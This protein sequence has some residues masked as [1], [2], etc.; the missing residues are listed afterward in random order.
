MKITAL[1]FILNAFIPWTKTIAQ[2]APLGL[3][4]SSSVQALCYDSVSDILYAGGAFQFL[5]APADSSYPMNRIARWDGV[6]WDSLGSGVTEFRNVFALTMYNGNLIAGGTFDTIGGISSKGIAMWDGTDWNFLA[7]ITST[8]NAGAVGE[9]YTH[10]TDL[11]VGGTFDTINGVPASG[12]ARFD[13]ANWYLYPVISNNYGI[14]AIIIFN[15]ELYIGG[16]FSDGVGKSDILKF[17]G[18]DWVSVGGGFSGGF[19]WVN[20]FEIYQNQLYVAGYFQQSS[21]DPGNNI[22]IWDGS[23]WSQAGSGTMPSNKYEGYAGV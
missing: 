22:A 14:A 16:N 2:F 10:G 5:D 19:T 12:I 4:F 21:G 8:G 11:Y 15:N 6:Q 9:L 23:N 13:G 3:G 1:L 17:D 20:D 7:N 18:T